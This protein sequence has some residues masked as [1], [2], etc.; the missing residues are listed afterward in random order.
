M[1]SFLRSGE[2]E[3]KLVIEYLATAV[4]REPIEKPPFE[5]RRGR[6]R[7]QRVLGEIEVIDRLVVECLAARDTVSRQHGAVGKIAILLERR[8]PAIEPALA[9]KQV[10]V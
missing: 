4:V 7:L 2:Q 9:Q 10:G 8:A 6:G 5:L 1:T 3:S